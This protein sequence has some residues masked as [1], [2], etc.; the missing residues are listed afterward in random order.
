MSKDEAGQPAVDIW[1]ASAGSVA[2]AAAVA[3]AAQH[4]GGQQKGS[5]AAPPL[6]PQPRP[7]H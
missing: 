4:A 5:C 2:A 1:L 7:S 6:P 3:V